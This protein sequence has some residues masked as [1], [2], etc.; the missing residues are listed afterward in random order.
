MKTYKLIILALIMVL[1]NACKDG[2]IDDISSV[3]PGP[4][5]TAPEITVNFPPDGYELQ[6]NDEI[7]EINIDFEVRDDIEIKMVTLKINGSEIN[8]YDEF[9][10]YRIFTEKFLF[11][12][13]TTGRHVLTVEA[14]DLEGK[15]SELNVNFAKSPPYVSEY[16]GEVF[17][18]PFNNEYREMNSLELATA[19]GSPKFGDGIQGGTA[20]SGA[21]DSY[22][23]FPTTILQGASEVSASFWLKVDDSMD[24][25]GLLVVAPPADDNNDRTKGFRF[26]REA[27]DP[28]KQRFKLNA[29]T[30]TSDSWFDGGSNADVEANT[31]EWTHFAFT[32]SQTESVVYINGEVVAQGA[33]DGID[34]TDCNL[35]SIM[36]GAPNWTGWDHKSDGSSMDELR[37]FNKSLSQQD[38]Q[39]I[40]LKEKATFYMDFNGKYKDALSGTEATVNGNPTFAYGGGLKGDAYKGA[41]DSYLTFSTSDISVQGDEFSASMWVN[42][43]D[44]PDRAGVLVMGPQDTENPEAQNDRT[45]GFRFFREASHEGAMQRFKLNAGNG[46]ADSWF[47]G[48]DA[49]DVDAKSGNWVHLAFTIGTSDVKVYINGAEV[50]QGAFDGIDWTGCDILSVMSGAPR[51]TAWG[52]NSDESLMDELYLFDKYLTAEEVSLLRTDGL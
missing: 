31:G 34:W 32:I 16:E 42:I 15:T 27:G 7:A 22:L 47:D 13:V 51:F 1:V 44:L 36:S 40:M 50:S 3:E 33:F 25:A 10:D 24:R 38:I 45:K 48:G 43:N 23:T 29:G 5:E 35:I 14:T 52:H 26:F 30:G 39:T 6:T 4:D 20:Y 49:A 28:G 19:V 46:T 8:T 9:K 12:E 18:M 37:I 11:N 21:A 2:F 17:Y 41:S